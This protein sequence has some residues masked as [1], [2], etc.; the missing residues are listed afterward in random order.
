MWG[1]IDTCVAGVVRSKITETEILSLSRE[2]H[3]DRVGGRSSKTSRAGRKEQKD[4][5]IGKRERGRKCDGGTLGNEA[6]CVYCATELEKSRLGKLKGARG[7]DSWPGLET[8]AYRT[9]KARRGGGEFLKAAVDEIEFYSG[10][11]R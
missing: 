10:L 7:R 9:S 6:S 11:T 5:K 8:R 1:A 2:E 4:A 3:V